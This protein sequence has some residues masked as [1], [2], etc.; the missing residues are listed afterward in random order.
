[1][2]E[3]P[4]KNK[5]PSSGKEDDLL[6]FLL[7]KNEDKDFTFFL[8]DKKEKDNELPALF[9]DLDFLFPEEKK[10]DRRSP[11]L[12]G[13]KSLFPPAD[14][15]L[16]LTFLE[17]SKIIPPPATLQPEII[18]QKITETEEP[19]EW[20]EGQIIAG[21]YEVTKILG[22]GAFGSVYKV[23]HREWN[24]YLAVK[25]LKP[26][27]SED[28]SQ[29]KAFADEC[30]GWVNL[31]LH[32][33]IVSCYYVRTLGGL[34]RIFLEYIEGGSLFE[35][36]KKNEIKDLSEILDLSIQ[37]LE[38]LSFAHGR[39]L[40]HRDIK[41]LNCL[42]TPGGILKITDFG[43]ASGLTGLKG[44]ATKDPGEEETGFISGGA[45][46]TPAYMPPEQWDG[47]H[48][49]TGPWSDI[50][51]FGVMLYKMC[52]HRGPFDEKGMP[53]LAI[54]ARHLTHEPEIPSK[55]NPQIPESLSNFILRCIKKKPEK[56][57]QNCRE[58]VREL[59]NIYGEITGSSYG[60]KKPEEVKLLA[61]SLNNRAVSLL[62]LGEKKEALRIWE[63]A[64]KS[65]VYHVKSTFNRGI[66]KW[67]SG[68]ID[69]ITLLKELSHIR[70]EEPHDYEAH[71][72]AGLFHLER[73]DPDAAIKALQEARKISP[74]KNEIE[75]K[76]KVARERLF[77]STRLIK[78]V[79]TGSPSAGLYCLT[80]DKKKAIVNHH[81]LKI[82]NLTSGEWENTLETSFVTSVTT[83]GNMVLTG[84]HRVNS[85]SL[86]DFST[87][88]PVKNFSISQDSIKA[89]DIK[90]NLAAG[91]GTEKIIYI[92][93][94]SSGRTIH[95]LTGHR[96]EII[97]LKFTSDCILSG[98]SD[99]VIKVWNT[100]SGNCL[101]TIETGHKRD[102]IKFDGKGN[103]GI[104]IRNYL[105][106]GSLYETVN[107][108]GVWNISFG[109]CVNSFTSH[110]GE[111]ILSAGLSYDGCW[112]LIGGEG[113]TVNLVKLPEGQCIRTFDDHKSPV[114][115]VIISK[116]ATLALSCDWQGKINIRNINPHNFKYRTGMA[117]SEI[118]T[119]EI[120]GDTQ[121]RYKALLENSGKAVGDKNWH[122]AIK[123]VSEIRLLPGYE[124]DPEVLTLWQSLYPYCR[125]KSLRAIWLKK[126]FEVHDKWVMAAKFSFDGKWIVSGSKDGR[127]KILDINRGTVIKT[128][129]GNRGEVHSVDVSRDLK[130]I[131][132]G[133]A[134]SDMRL[135]DISTGR[136]I[137]TFDDGKSGIIESAV[138][139]SDNRLIL[140]AG[141]RDNK[142]KL[143]DV[144]S[145]DCIKVFEIPDG[146]SL[147][148][149]LSADNKFALS[150][151]YQRT[152]M[153]TGNYYGDKTIKVWD[154]ASGKCI[155]TIE[156]PSGGFMSLELSPDGK[157]LLTGNSDNTISLWDLS[158][159]NCLKTF[160]QSYK[161]GVKSISL[162]S[163]KA[164]GAS[165]AGFAFNIWDME[166]SRCVKTV[167]EHKGIIE[168]VQFSPDMAYLLTGSQDNTIKL[169][170]LDWELEAPEPENFQKEPGKETALSRLFNFF[171]K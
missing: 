118:E 27:L 80:E 108:I 140:S 60:R 150:A 31:G 135:F 151:S 138:L 8:P 120:K 137:K 41:P 61:D 14:K 162:S 46:G 47:R 28:E 22:E 159:E 67:H 113:Q 52:C 30:Q 66:I 82:L 131:L 38:G 56:R 50:Y 45:V 65:D 110:G 96:D 156:G 77:S 68:D 147:K 7:G 111:K 142:M 26:E 75:E 171:R 42:L 72:F 103:M 62:D 109:T 114:S 39:G 4:D 88:R 153:S 165:S 40:V 97:S 81:D 23:R 57:F 119:A 1:L 16:S 51:A 15:T 92:I 79:E 34:P 3:K 6:S 161:H 12:N 87:G 132:A 146:S 129:E 170:F 54:K 98:S 100:S 112:L 71:Y 126:T 167:E 116:D 145:G 13:E 10:D 123:R 89:L 69:D 99:G 24:K 158:T 130:F 124:K 32:P 11:I 152:S 127:V 21:L 53:A 105:K 139:S 86:W 19:E 74:G 166:G 133:Y 154:I 35:R 164:F 95:R 106:E 29:K 2:K 107:E 168:T 155:K 55:I 59:E 141:S 128:F 20:K 49:K 36:I 104:T 163:D 63:E 169:W 17:E 134:G 93:D 9:D 91:A 18:P 85:M 94:I 44:I 90:G 102:I 48:G 148:V 136:C 70:T 83:A 73:D 115:S 122:E 5:K 64:L 58:A 157:H 37:C 76:L 121:S 144:S 160:N 43:I 143:R 101:K 25:S 78:T 117:L 84:H 149:A 125:K 33:N